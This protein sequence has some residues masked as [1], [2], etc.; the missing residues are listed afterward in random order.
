MSRIILIIICLS[1]LFGASAQEAIAPLVP[2]NIP[3]ERTK[4]QKAIGISTDVTVLA[5]PVAALTTAIIERDW[6]GIGQGAIAGGVS[7][8]AMLILKYSVRELRPD[9]SNYHSFPSG[10]S[11]TAFVAAAFMQRRYGWKWGIPA[12]AVATYTGIGRVLAKKHH[13]WDVV[14][15][16]AIG[17]GGAYIF[18]TPWAKDHEI[19]VIPSVTDTYTGLS[20]SATF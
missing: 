17:V 18:T 2:E 19:A 11:T 9:R 4:A 14:A 15:G 12:Y 10:H 8:G 13:W 20:L 1:A 16:A 6:K 7:I 3:I 5:L